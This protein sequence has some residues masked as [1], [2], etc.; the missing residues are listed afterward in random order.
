MNMISDEVVHPL[1]LPTQYWITFNEEHSI[2]LLQLQII[3]SV[4][5][6]MILQNNP[7]KQQ[8]LGEGCEGKWPPIAKG[9]STQPPPE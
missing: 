6:H 9:K 2:H 1:Y 4:Q 5:C 8:N 7:V 3:Y